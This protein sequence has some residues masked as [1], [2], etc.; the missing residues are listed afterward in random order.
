MSSL[1]MKS[2]QFDGCAF[3]FEIDGKRPKRQWVVKTTND[4]IGKELESRSVA[5]GRVLTIN[6][7]EL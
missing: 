7:K 2:V 4:R 1:G 5:M 3:D 6:L